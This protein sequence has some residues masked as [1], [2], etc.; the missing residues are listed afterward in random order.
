[1]TCIILEQNLKR[2]PEECISQILKKSLNIESDIGT[3]IQQTS[4]YFILKNYSTHTSNIIISSDTVFQSI[5]DDNSDN[6]NDEWKISTLN[7]IRFRTS[8]ILLDKLMRKKVKSIMEN[9]K[10]N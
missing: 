2:E 7:T 9:S 4:N 5:N 8:K 6:V 3:Y 10:M 1:M